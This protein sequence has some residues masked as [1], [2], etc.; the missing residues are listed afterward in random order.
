[1][2]HCC[3]VPGC[4]NRSDRESHLSFFKLPLK[5]KA[6]LKQ[7]VH[8]IGRKNLPINPNTRVCSEHF[9]QAAGRLLQHDEVPSLRLPILSTSPRVGKHRKPPR[10][11]DVWIAVLDVIT[12]KLIKGFVEFFKGWSLFRVFV[13][14][15]QHY[16]ISAAKR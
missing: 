3:S 1:M 16:L 13:P 6:L 14:A 8:R 4:S 7:W 15:L 10:K 11:F 5:N 9:V 2:V 12:E